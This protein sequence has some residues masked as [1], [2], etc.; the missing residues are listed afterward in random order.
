MSVHRA[1]DD[2]KI[3]GDG[4]VCASFD[5]GDVDQGNA[6]RCCRIPRLRCGPGPDPGSVFARLALGGARQ[7]RFAVAIDKGYFKA[8]GLDVTIDPAAALAS[9][10]P[11][12]IRHL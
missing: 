10:S 8:E 11:R 4:Y 2:K 6:G 1:R 12:G 5:E 3:R 9:R 7:P